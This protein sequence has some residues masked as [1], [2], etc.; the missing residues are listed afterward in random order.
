MS[1]SVPAVKVEA[2]KDASWTTLSGYYGGT[3]NMTPNAAARMEL[4]FPNPGGRN[5]NALHIGQRIRLTLGLDGLP[6][7]P[8]FLGF[9]SNRSLTNSHGQAS[10]SFECFDFLGLAQREQVK[11]TPSGDNLDGYDAGSAVKAVLESMNGGDIAALGLSTDGVI[12]VTGGRP[13]E[14]KDGVYASDYNNKL[15]IIQT[16]NEMS[17]IDQYPNPPRPYA[18]LQD[19]DGVF[20]HRPVEDIATGTPRL[21]VQYAGNLSKLSQKTRTAK[22]LNDCTVIGQTDAFSVEDPK[23]NLQGTFTDQSSMDAHGRW[24]G[25][26]TKGWLDSVDACRDY[27]MRKVALYRDYYE[28][29]SVELRRGYH[30]F[31]GDLVNLTNVEQ[32]ARSENMRVMELDTMFQPGDFTVRLT[33]GAMNYLPTEYI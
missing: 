23:P 24:S 7:Y 5:L 12:G 9:V 11:Y 20:H 4:T 6:V 31:V 13:V 10:A 28:P 21:T 33:L 25:K 19:G 22:L 8:R 2:L 29:V 30:L 27:A 16:L 26:F 1:M 3:F 18:V 14:E 15:S 17:F 32:A